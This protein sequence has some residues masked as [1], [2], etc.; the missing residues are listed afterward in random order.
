LGLHHSYLLLEFIIHLLARQCEELL[1]LSEKFFFRDS[2]VLKTIALSTAL[3]SG[4]LA[5]I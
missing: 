5:I 4:L 1:L 2:E 3:C